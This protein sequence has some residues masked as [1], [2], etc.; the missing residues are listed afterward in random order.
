[1]IRNK[2]KVVELR[3]TEDDQ[4]ER[5]EIHISPQLI[6]DA[7]QKGIRLQGEKYLDRLRDTLSKDADFIGFMRNDD[8]E[9]F[10]RSF[11][12]LKKNLEKANYSSPTARTLISIESFSAQGLRK[13]I[14]D[15]IGQLAFQL[16]NISPS[17]VMRNEHETM[18][19]SLESEIEEEEENE[20]EE[21]NDFEVVNGE[22]KTV[23]TTYSS[24]DSYAGNN[25]LQA[26]KPFFSH[27][28][29]TID[30]GITVEMKVS[31][32]K[33]QQAVRKFRKNGDLRQSHDNEAEL[34]SERMFQPRSPSSRVEAVI[35]TSTKGD[36][37]AIRRPHSMQAGQTTS[38]VSETNGTK[39]ESYSDEDNLR[40]AVTAGDTG[41]VKK[42]NKIQKAWITNQQW[43]LGE[44]IG[45]GS[46]GDVF[47]VLNDKVI[48]F[49]ELIL[50]I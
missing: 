4:Y 27:D 31:P 23:S 38:K 26:K 40:R 3:S 2:P 6:N 33:P 1:M 20:Y 35:S 21:D 7:F 36:I 17:S 39:E 14:V 42:R 9:Q 30:K 19:D 11:D 13:Q 41:D 10:Y 8:K 46:F 18:E 50:Y 48:F 44:M 22:C 43:K 28:F 5:E 29:G 32:S 15:K 16:E 24:L 12:F 25:H 47:K 34:K 49:G 37:D 45:S